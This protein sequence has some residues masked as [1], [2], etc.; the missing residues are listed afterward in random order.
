MEPLNGLAK[1]DEGPID[2]NYLRGAG[3]DY[4]RRPTVSYATAL[5][6]L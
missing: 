4:F 5:L 2:R 3:G 1:M 6:L